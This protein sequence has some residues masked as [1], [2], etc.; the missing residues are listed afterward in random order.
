[1]ARAKKQPAAAPQPAAKRRGR[2][3]KEKAPAKQQGAGRPSIFKAEYCEKLIE[4]CEKGLSFS[5]CAAEFGISR[6]TLYLWEETIPAFA[7]AKA[8][9]EAK[10]LRFWE[11]LAIDASRGGLSGQTKGSAA[12]II[13]QICNRFPQLYR[14]RVEIADARDKKEE[15][16]EL[17]DSALQREIEELTQIV[18]TK[19][20]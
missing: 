8:I 3:K 19:Q 5:A 6:R 13:H 17:S 2:P 4:L 18:N 16:K 20:S 11:E 1:M 7:E 12:V 15:V 10:S 14:Q 9:A